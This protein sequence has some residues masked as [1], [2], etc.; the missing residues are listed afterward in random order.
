MNKDDTHRQ[1]LHLV[2]EYVK[3]NI[4]LEERVSLNKTIEVRR[5]LSEIRRCASLRRKEIMDIQIERKKQLDIQK[6]RSI[7]E[8]ADDQI[9]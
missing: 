8:E 9:D 5:L 3:A 7:S 4:A 6:G 1:M 2:Y